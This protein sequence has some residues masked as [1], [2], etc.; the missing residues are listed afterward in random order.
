[1]AVAAKTWRGGSGDR[2]GLTCSSVKVELV[3]PV[4]LEP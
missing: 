2:E 4:A 3:A 1:M